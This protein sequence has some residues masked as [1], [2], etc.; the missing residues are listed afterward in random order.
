MMIVMMSVILMMVMV[1]VSVMV[2]KVMVVGVIPPRE[3]H[4]RCLHHSS[5]LSPFLW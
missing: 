1:V 2:V 3:H 5:P 4:Q